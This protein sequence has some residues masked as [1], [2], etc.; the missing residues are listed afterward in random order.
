MVKLHESPN[1]T[2]V[3]I[4]H[5]AQSHK[6]KFAADKMPAPTYIISKVADPIFAVMIG[7]GAA[8]TRINREEKELGRTTEETL[9]ALKR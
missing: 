1:Q 2:V 7:L 8:T 5:T 3:Y 6:N 9:N 4:R